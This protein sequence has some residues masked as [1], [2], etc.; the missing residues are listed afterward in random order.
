MTRTRMPSNRLKLIIIFIPALT[1]IFA[2]LQLSL[3]PSSEVDELLDQS[4]EVF[5]HDANAPEPQ[6][7]ERDIAG[8]QNVQN[9]FE[10]VV[11]DDTAAGRKNKKS[12]QPES[13]STN[14]IPLQTKQKDSLSLTSP[15]PLPSTGESGFETKTE[16]ESKAVPAVQHNVTNS[17]ATNLEQLID[18]LIQQPSTTKSL[19]ILLKSLAK[20]TQSMTMTDFDTITNVTEET[21]RCQRYGFAFNPQRKTRRRIFFGSNIADDTWHALA[22]HAAEA[23]GLYHTIAFI[24]SNRTTSQ[25]TKFNRP[26]ELRFSPDSLNYKVLQSGVFGP[27]TMVSVDFYAGGIADSNF[28]EPLQ[29]EEA[30]KRWKTNGM[31]EDDIAVFS[32]VDEV[33]TRD[34]LLA[35]KT[36]EIPQF[37]KGQ[38]CQRP[39]LM[40]HTTV[41][42]SSP[43]CIDRKSWHHPDMI[44]GECVETIRDDNIHKPGERSLRD[45]YHL[46]EKYHLMTKDNSNI[47]MFPLWKPFDFRARVGGRMIE[48]RKHKQTGFHFRNFFHS[49]KA[50]RNKMQTYTHA[51]HYRVPMPPLSEMQD[52]LMMAVNCLMDRPDPVNARKKRIM[53]G[54]DAISGDVPILFQNAEYRKARH[55]EVV[56]MIIEDE[57]K[58]GSHV[59][60]SAD[61]K[62]ADEHPVKS[63]HGSN[64]IVNAQQTIGRESKNHTI[65]DKIVDPSMAATVI[66]MATNMRLRTF[67]R[68]VG[69]LRKAEY[70]GHI[71]LGLSP[72]NL[73]DPLVLDYLSSQNVTMKHVE[74]ISCTHKLG[75]EG[76]ASPYSDIK[77]RWSR[78]PLARDWL[79]DCDTCTGPVMVTDVRDTL[80]QANPFGRTPDGEAPPVIEGLQVF[81]ENPLQTTDHWLIEWPVREC[82]NVTFR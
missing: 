23:H 57:A 22:V 47:T 41:F 28:H 70:K 54:F 74:F 53:G 37:Q 49:T 65:V 8:F 27:D 5:F 11:Q 72:K 21:E 4:N 73:M 76:C 61:I 77:L 78:F 42:E 2:L 50:L 55:Q 63:N 19:Q 81:E 44:I 66:G 15:F 16:T 31:T 3:L 29:R 60:K 46:N 79:I 32:D 33:F 69:S 58:Y 56:D 45:E 35:A 36:C 10:D 48:G 68:F 71:I 9:V 1:V 51:Q 64:N 67:K 20:S 43:E 38:D 80:F 7:L 52:E 75:T 59:Q 30:L 12:E 39:K 18:E 40:G 25:L 34:F 26:R 82:K 6:S 62:D 17:T 24:E 14:K 13:E